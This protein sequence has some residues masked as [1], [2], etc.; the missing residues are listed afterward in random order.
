MSWQLVHLADVAPSRWRNGAGVTRELLAWPSAQDWIWRL[1]V[2]EVA[3][4]GLFSRF[5]GV[6][7]WFAVLHGAGVRLTLGGQT[8]DLTRSS[9]PLCFD[10]GLPV[11]CQL[12]DGATQD[13]NLML[14]PDKVAAKMRRV[15]GDIS[16][17]LDAPEIIAVYAMD[18]GAGVYFDHINLAI[19]A[20]SL[21]W[22]AL[23]AGARVQ[24]SAA[25]ALWMEIKA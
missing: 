6:Q 13:F 24:L 11:D 22:Q 9:A 17:V 2:A 10:G 15:A 23:P 4:S 16:F 20:H 12:L 14:R 3:Q 21:A 19:P 5:E 1:S 25:D 8:H 18:T 7:R